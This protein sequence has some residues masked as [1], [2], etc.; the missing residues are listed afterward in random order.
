M[1]GAHLL[2]RYIGDAHR[3]N[4]DPSL[5]I[6]DKS[7][8]GLRNDVQCGAHLTVHRASI[9]KTDHV[10]DQCQKCGHACHGV[11]L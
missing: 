8:C 7:K 6:W 4:S 10:Q 3:Y 9:G 5:R 2:V 1:I 11:N